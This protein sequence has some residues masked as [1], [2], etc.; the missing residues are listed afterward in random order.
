M[1][2]YENM[3]LNFVIEFW[4]GVSCDGWIA[5]KWPAERCPT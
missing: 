4:E 2:E 5:S 1:V 3:K